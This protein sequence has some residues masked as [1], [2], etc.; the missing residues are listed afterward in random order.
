M[1]PN[2]KFSQV[3]GQIPFGSKVLSA[4]KGVLSKLWQMKRH[5]ELTQLQDFSLLDSFQFCKICI[6]Y[7]EVNDSMSIDVGQHR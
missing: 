6:A 4:T 2:L 7:I 5:S 3:K 1:Q